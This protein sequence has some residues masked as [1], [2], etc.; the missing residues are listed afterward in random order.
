MNPSAPSFDLDFIAAHVLPF[1]RVPSAVNAM[2]VSKTWYAVISTSASYW[3]RHRDA[4]QKRLSHEV[5]LP[6]LNVL[7]SLSI[8]WLKC[9]TWTQKKKWLYCKH[10]NPYCVYIDFVIARYL[11]MRWGDVQTFNR[12]DLKDLN[13]PKGVDKKNAF[14]VVVKNFSGLRPYQNGFFTHQFCF[15]QTGLPPPGDK[16]RCFV[17]ATQGKENSWSEIDIKDFF[18][19]FLEWIFGPE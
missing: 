13:C 12:F 14:I 1:L 11:N 17:Q 7:S 15:S 3:K 2:Q 4:L 8:K 9:T 18:A 16:L 19:P 10:E 6:D 5:H